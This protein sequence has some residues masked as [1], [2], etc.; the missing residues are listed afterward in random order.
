MQRLG[1]Q[2]HQSARIQDVS[3]ESES[4]S[5][6][7]RRSSASIHG[8]SSAADVL[9][10]CHQY[11]RYVE[12]QQFLYYAV[13]LSIVSLVCDLYTDAAVLNHLTTNINS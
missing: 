8:P 4:S 2:T 12:S 11:V 10:T 6:G 9:R 1:L 5:S 3:M 13:G 7:I